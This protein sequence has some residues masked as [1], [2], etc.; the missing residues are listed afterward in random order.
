M[1]IFL[2][3]LPAP[4]CSSNW[5]QRDTIYLAPYRLQADQLLS[6]NSAASSDFQVGS[7]VYQDA[8]RAIPYLLK[9]Y[10][11]LGRASVRPEAIP[12]LN[13]LYWLLD[14]NPDIVVEIGS[15]TD[16]RGT[17]AFNYRLSQRRANAIVRF[18]VSK[19]IS[20]SRL[21]AKGYGETRL[22]NGCANGVDCTEDDHQMNRRTEFRVVAERMGQNNR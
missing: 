22:V 19:G 5:P 3:F 9:V 15:H 17:D 4:Y 10:Y 6:S 20:S 18:L 12:E 14:R 16:A 13:R 11:D 1:D 8:D 2:V 21:Q 7:Q